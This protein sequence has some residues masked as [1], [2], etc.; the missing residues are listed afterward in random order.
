METHITFDVHNEDIFGAVMDTKMVREGGGGGDDEV[1][2]AGLFQM[3][4]MSSW[5]AEHRER[6]NH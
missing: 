6:K 4:D 1:G 3:H 5:N 2:D